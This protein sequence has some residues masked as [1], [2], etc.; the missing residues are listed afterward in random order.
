MTNQ[1]NHIATQE[2]LRD[3]A[4]AA[5]K[6]AETYE[7]MLRQHNIARVITKHLRSL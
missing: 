1:A 2:A 6:T 7:E 3:T 4:I 5:S